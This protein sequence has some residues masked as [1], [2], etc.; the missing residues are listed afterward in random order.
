MR[1]RAGLLAECHRV[2]RPGGR[3]VLCDI[4]RRREIPFLEVRERRSEFGT[5]RRAFG[6]AH[7]MPLEDY[8]ATLADHGMT[9]LDATDLTEP[10]FPTFAAWRRNIEAHET[11]LVDLIGRAGVDDF[12]SSTHILE[13]FWRDGTLGYGILAAVR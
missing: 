2:L 3:L 6:D 8:C 1:D 7:M 13:T 9:V 4:V 5:L 10:T 12:V 11:T